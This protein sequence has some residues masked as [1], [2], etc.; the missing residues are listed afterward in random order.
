MPASPGRAYL[1]SPGR[2]THV[3]TINAKDIGTYRRP[4]GAD[5]GS[6]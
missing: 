6:L 3:F 5:E 2:S 4:G 1:P